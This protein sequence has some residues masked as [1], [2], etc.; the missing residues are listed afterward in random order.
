MTYDA[1]KGELF[2]I[3]MQQDVVQGKK[4]MLLEKG[5]TTRDPQMLG[6]IRYINKMTYGKE[7][8]IVRAD[9]IHV[10]WGD[11]NIRSMMNWSVQDYYERFRKQGW[12]GILPELLTRIQNAGQGME[13]LHMEEDG[14]EA[15]RDRL[16]LRPINYERNRFELEHCIFWKFGDIALTLYGIVDDTEED[17]VT[18]KIH[19][20]LIKEWGMTDDKLLTEALHRTGRLMPPRIY[21]CTDLKRRHEWTEGMFMPEEDTGEAE[22]FQA[23]T[24]N[25]REGVL[26]YRITTTRNLNGAIAVFYPGV[27]E[28]LARMM[29]GDYYLGFTSIHEA[30][31]HPVCRQDTENMKSSIREINEVFPGEE[32]L[33]NKVYRYIAATG[34][35]AEV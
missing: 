1:F 4:V 26:G 13:W 33:T 32:M 35:L 15:S 21:L 18:M 27:K 28:Q 6:M 5:F 19:R 30:V 16:I 17:F 20:S 2:R 25:Q 8:N 22:L 29:G 3:I 10:V 11:G 31:I 24:E 12:E 34:V 14:Y 7:E 23:D 9:Y